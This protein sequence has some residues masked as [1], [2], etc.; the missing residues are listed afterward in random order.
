MNVPELKEVIAELI[1]EQLKS[2]GRE[3]E[4]VKQTVEKFSGETVQSLAEAGE[5]ATYLQMSREDAK[6]KLA[7]LIRTA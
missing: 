4:D 2:R 3:Q 1:A 7:G 5:L 6:T